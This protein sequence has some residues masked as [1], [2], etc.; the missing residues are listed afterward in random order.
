M[1]A[2]RSTFLVLLGASSLA[3]SAGA[4]YAQ[5]T[6]SPSATPQG[7][8]SKDPSNS[9]ET[10]SPSD[11]SGKQKDKSKGAKEQTSKKQPCKSGD[12]SNVNCK[13]S[14]GSSPKQ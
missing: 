9:S 11:S 6:S 10:S 7:S 4:V 1:K 3:L 14:S 8:M 5:A 13:P 12:N 2:I